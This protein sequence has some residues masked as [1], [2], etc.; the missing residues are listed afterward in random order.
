MT[1]PKGA[2]SLL[3]FGA[4]LPGYSLWGSTGTKHDFPILDR[5]PVT[6]DAIA[7]LLDRQLVALCP[8]RAPVIMFSGGVDSALLAARVAQL[9]W[10]DAVL[11]HYSFGEESADTRAAHE[12][13]RELG[14]RMKTVPHHSSEALRYLRRMAAVYPHPFVDPSTPWTGILIEHIAAEWPDRRFI[15]DGTGADGLFGMLGFHRLWR[16]VYRL[17]RPVRAAVGRL[18][19]AQALKSG[20]LERYIRIIRRSD[21]HDLFAASVLCSNAL[22][23]LAYHPPKGVEQ[24]VREDLRALSGAMDA[25]DADRLCLWDIAHNCRSKFAQKS[26]PVAAHLG[27][28]VVFPFLA[29][30]AVSLLPSIRAMGDTELKAPLKRLLARRIGRELVYRDK[31]PFTTPLAPVFRESDIRSVL[32]DPDSHPLAAYLDRSYVSR[33]V[34]ASDRLGV[35]SEVFLWALVFSSY[36]FAAR[37]TTDS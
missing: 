11:A 33:L 24:R 8:D 31:Q 28:T 6:D 7:E 5:R 17:P 30:A 32:C 15:I 36:W 18:Y 26:A 35:Q 37:R 2:Y 12:I 13:A 1:D 10:R 4:L 25:A 3:Q 27:K 21:Q 22:S 14:L 34:A 29:D 23:G 9:G 19:R 20:R 16:R